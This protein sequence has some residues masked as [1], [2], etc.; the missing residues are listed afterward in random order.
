MPDLPETVA[1]IVG[2]D[3]IEAA[4]GRRRP[5]TPSELARRVIQHY[6]TT[7]ALELIS[8]VLNDAIRNPGRRLV[9]T[10]PPRSGKSLLVSIIGVLFALMVDPDQ[11]VIQVTYADSLSEEFSHQAKALAAEYA[12]LLGFELSSDRKAVGRWKISGRRGGVLACGI[13]SGVTGHGA[14]LVICDDVLKNQAEADSPSQKRKLRAEFDNTIMTRLHPGASVCVIQTRWSTDDLA[15][16]LLSE[17]GR[18][19]QYVNI[20]AIS[21]EGIE[22]ALEREPGEVMTSALGRTRRELDEVRS[23]ISSRSWYSL[24]QGSPVDPAG[25]LIRSEWL[26]DSRLPAAPHPLRRIVIG[27]DPADSGRGDHAGIVAAG[28]T[29]AGDVV[30]LRSTSRQMTPDVWS[31]EA[32]RMAY[33]TGATAVSIEGFASRKGY[34]QIVTAAV[35]RY[36]AAH[37]GA[38][39]IRVSTWPPPNSGR[40]G[41]AEAR[42]AGLL[43]ALE[44]GGCR[45]VGQHPAIEDA[46]AVWQHGSHQPDVLA[47]LTIAH[48]TLTRSSTEITLPPAELFA[49]SLGHG[50]RGGR[51]IP[52]SPY[53][54]RRVDGR[55]V[56]RHVS[57]SASWLAEAQALRP[58]D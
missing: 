22:D 24:Y 23:R 31:T 34:E 12:D 52:I 49:Q 42:S 3:L 14:G 46:A 48:D 1:A 55:R 41:N 20:P 11:N 17:D 5:S 33:E 37:P 44:R 27:V 38:A 9:I 58:L 32:V 30:V 7:P 57:V 50:G 4:R 8:D 2:A 39:A 10:T 54:A 36:R 16:S 15:G 29:A 13:M 43:V 28:L 51:V 19:W 56:R 26:A 53:L 35:D 40:A 47:A 21:E 6:V 25:G 45:L 18:S